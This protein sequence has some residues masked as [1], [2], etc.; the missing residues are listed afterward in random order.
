MR[1]GENAMA[2]RWEH[3][4][5]FGWDANW[6]PW[7]SGRPGHREFGKPR[8]N[9]IERDSQDCHQLN[10]PAQKLMGEKPSDEGQFLDADRHVGLPTA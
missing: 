3:S 4:T 2:I 1:F 7:L 6:H 5:N 9:V 10:Q 8:H